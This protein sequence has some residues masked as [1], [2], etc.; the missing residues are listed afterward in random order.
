MWLGHDSTWWLAVIALVSM[1]PANLLANFLTPRIQNW[2]A[3]RS[4]A[5]LVR[6]IS[7]LEKIVRDAKSVP[8]FTPFEHVVVFGLSVLGRMVMSVT[9]LIIGLVIIFSGWYEGSG[10]TIPQVIF[11]ALF[12]FT[13][14]KTLVQSRYHA[15]LSAPLNMGTEKG[16]EELQASLAKLKTKLAIK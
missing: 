4:R 2:W 14:A 8:P 11:F 7:E 1:L 9:T 5:S 13:I 16:R 15:L 6:R 3:G 10:H 12:V